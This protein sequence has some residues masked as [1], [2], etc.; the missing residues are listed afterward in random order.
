MAQKY[1]AIPEPVSDINSV[2]TATASLKEGFEILTGIR[3]SKLSKAITY[4]D[5]LDL[6]LINITQV[7]K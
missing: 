2:R 7:P 5:L 4:Q 1:P 6:G 3:G